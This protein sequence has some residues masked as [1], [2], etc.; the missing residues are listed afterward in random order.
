[1]FTAGVNEDWIYDGD[2]KIQA[3]PVDNYF[4]P[5]ERQTHFLGEIVIKQHHTL[6]QILMGLLCAGFVLE[7]VEEAQ[8]PAERMDLP[9]MKEELRR[10]MML[11]VRARKPV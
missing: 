4:Y 1:M 9:E 5:G 2:G 8:P 3:W 7:A 6:T 11:L 10:P